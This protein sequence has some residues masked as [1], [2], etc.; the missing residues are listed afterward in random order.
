M[1][2]R[3]LIL[4]VAI[5]VTGC[6]RAGDGGADRLRRGD[7]ALRVAL[8]IVAL[9]RSQEHRLTREQAGKILPLLKVLR[10]TR[11]EDREVAE[12]I[13]DQVQGVL[14]PEQR[15]ALQKLREEARERVRRPGGP[16][17][18]PPGRGQDGP[19]SDPAR[20]AEFRQRALDRAIRIVEARAKS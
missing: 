16:G 5:L 15:A 19:G 10:D 13:A 8:A 3:W 1:R 20:R 2:Q 17:P 18:G 12:A 14:T 11:A 4:L 6:S 9:E 7:P